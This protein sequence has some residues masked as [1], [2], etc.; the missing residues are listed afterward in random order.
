MFVDDKTMPNLPSSVLNVM[1]NGRSSARS[2]LA[3]PE[4][5][6]AEVSIPFDYMVSGS[7][8]LRVTVK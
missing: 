2:Y 3:T 5:A 4:T 8:S 1:Q 7:H 6:L